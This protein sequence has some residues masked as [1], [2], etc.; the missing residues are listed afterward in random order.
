MLLKVTEIGDQAFYWCFLLNELKFESASM[1][2]GANAFENC[3]RL[4][5]I[6]FSGVITEIGTDVFKDANT[7]NYTLVLA[8]SQKDFIVAADGSFTISDTDVVAG[9]NAT[10]CGYTFKEIIIAEE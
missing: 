7:E 10:F 1:K 6:E 2:I 3:I 5:K 9:A 8:K 4:T